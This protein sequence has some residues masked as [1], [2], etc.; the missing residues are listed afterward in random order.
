MRG[1]E[2]AIYLEAS[3]TDV[4]KEAD[5][6]SASG[7][8]SRLGF[9][10]SILSFYK[11]ALTSLLAAVLV[12]SSAIAPGVVTFAGRFIVSRLFIGN[13]FAACARFAAFSRFAACARSVSR[14]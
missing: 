11:L 5:V 2:P 3:K 10:F 9:T 1:V 4:L 14:N 13:V 6:W 12:Q 8:A 7:N